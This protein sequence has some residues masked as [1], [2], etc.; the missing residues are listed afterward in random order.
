MSSTAANIARRFRL[1][2]WRL[3]LLSCTAL[4]ALDIGFVFFDVNQAR[5]ILRQGGY[6]FILL[7]FGLW[8]A[9]LWR[10][11]PANHADEPMPK[12]DLLMAASLVALLLLVALSQ[13]T[14]R[15]KILFDEYVLQS[16]AY[17]MHFFR[18]NSA[19][20][21]GYDVQGMFLSMD[22]YVDKRPAFF[23]FLLSLLHDLLGYRR[24]NVFLL[25]AGLFVATLGLVWWIGWQLNGRRGGL[26]AAGL[27]G[28][29]PLLAQNASG[30][31]M[32]LLNI[33]MLLVV[34]LSAAGW[35]ARP[36]EARLSAFVL[37]VVLLVQSRYESALY[38][39]PAVAVILLGWWKGKK[40]VVSWIA[41]MAPLLFVPTAL[42][43]KMISGSPIMWELR[44]NQTA[45]F[46]VD[47]LADNLRGAWSF[48]T[49]V[50]SAQANS[51]LLGLLG[52]PA[53]LC[54]GW[55]LGRAKQP[56]VELAPI[57]QSL[58]LFGG[59][60]LA[61][62]ALIMFYYWASFSDSMAA[63]FALPLHLLLILAVVAVAAWYDRRWPVSWIALVV[64][65]I[66]T[67]GSSVPKQ[68]YHFYS[69]M[70]N[71]EVEWE[72]RVVAGR[73]SVN[74]LIITN[75]ST[76][77][78]LIDQTPA[79]L[80]ERSRAV[81]DRLAEQLAMPDFAEI[82]VTQG[83]RPTSKEGDFQLP[84]DEVL[85]EWFHLQ[86]LTE[87]RFGTKL[88]RI[89]RLISIDLPPDFKSSTPPP[90]TSGDAGPTVHPGK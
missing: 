16:T 37:G 89:S 42:L 17:N 8:L 55:R 44:E 39:L 72:R 13:E 1:P 29:L 18:D 90:M 47:Y 9:V 59:G 6:Y 45:R 77:P 22:S 2:Q 40:V 86:L 19:M 79:I 60:M 88:A 26:L 24:E 80:L 25:N 54:I 11:R 3:A 81:A 20:V 34:M 63:R 71:D 30:A 69:H 41:V 4:V 38:V 85:P 53:L 14:F 15:S 76:L 56:V 73:P 12:K 48:F 87:R 84:P 51:L 33:G 5:Q 66:F 52:F 82:L 7:T 65:A 62:T 74:R 31:G 23:P 58:L 43:Q 68:A 35:L 67:L 32:E 57:R 83:A 46:S 27:L 64:V 70:G 36:D 28:T 10:L 50:G 49:S 61:A 78:W 21:R 75:K